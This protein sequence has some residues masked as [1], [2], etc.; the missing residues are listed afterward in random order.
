M[1]NR[2]DIL[3]SVAGPIGQQLARINQDVDGIGKTAQKTST[4]AS[5]S[6][7]DIGRIA[8]ASFAV[9]GAAAFAF[10][11]SAVDA[12]NAAERAALGL[13]SVATF[14]G[15]GGDAAVAALKNLDLVKSGLLTL[16]DASTTLKNLLQTGFSLDQSIELIKR[17]GDAAAFGRQAALTFGRAIESTSEGI[18]N[19]N[20]I[21]S[22]NAGITKNLS[23]ILRERGFE[24]QDINDK[25][26][27]AAAREA[28]YNGLL[29]ETQAQVGDAAK[30]TD[31]F[32][33]QTAKLSAAFDRLLQAIGKAITENP[34]LKKAFDDVILS[35]EKLIT[36]LSDP[37]SSA[38]RFVESLTNAFSGMLE[39]L[40][41]IKPIIEFIASFKGNDFGE[42]GTPQVGKVD[43]LQGKTP[44]QF[45]EKGFQD[46]QK[47]EAEKKRILETNAKAATDQA[48]TF[49]KQQQKALDAI[50][51]LNIRAEDSPIAR[52][53][54]EN[55]RR[56]D[57]FLRKNAEVGDAIKLQFIKAS[58]AARDA[59]IGK[60]L[61]KIADDARK[62]KA[63]L[64]DAFT[65]LFKTKLS[66]ALGIGDL[67]TEIAKLQAG[68]AGT[69]R[70]EGREA[71][72]ADRARLE[73]ELT[74]VIRSGGGAEIASEVN[75]LTAEINRLDIAE[76][77]ERITRESTDR[78]VQIA[79][80]MLAQAQSAGERG[81]ALE[82]II[83]ATSNIEQLTPEQIEARGR[84]ITESITV[85]ADIQ[86]EAV[87]RQQELIDTTKNQIVASEKLTGAVN[88]LAER[89]VVTVNVVGIPTEVQN[90]PG[91]GLGD[92]K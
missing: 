39:V 29:V 79:E 37:N 7:A 6:F 69:G 8:V 76:K 87:A 64:Q 86:K 45:L 55:T 38:S 44:A 51:K 18:R 53:Y 31:T 46:F 92:R 73:A 67:Q 19:G 71:R 83:S 14:K 59:D 27:G 23:V 1:A 41:K 34:R 30:L 50:T 25:V 2:V 70:T 11:K 84:A 13:Q 15:V 42:G 20:S 48:Q 91:G 32:A 88:M 90:I 36:E 62:M 26:K 74:A 89:G 43:F 82:A 63:S 47:K 61:L 5:A 56:I 57:E 40:S 10:G 85:Q 80:A 75:R 52:L 54:E 60:E 9:A 65:N 12:F 3:F 58:N 72:D 35:I 17:F 28:L 22:D 24:L 81:A 78:Q 77:L 66:G 68:L 16:T 33:G 21:L 4:L 49:T